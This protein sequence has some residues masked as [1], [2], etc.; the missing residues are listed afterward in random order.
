MNVPT[1]PT[2]T[3]VDE[4]EELLQ[5]VRGQNIDGDIA[6]MTPDELW[7]VYLHLLLSAGE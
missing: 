4:L 1:V 5:R 7:G 2:P 3:W 6:S